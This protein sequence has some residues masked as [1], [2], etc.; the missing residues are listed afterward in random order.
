MELLQSYHVIFNFY[1]AKKVTINQ[2]AVR[3]SVLAPYAAIH[4]ATGVIWGS[5]YAKSMSGPIQLNWVP[6]PCEMEDGVVKYQITCDARDVPFIKEY[7][8]QHG[9]TAGPG[10]ITVA[11]NAEVNVQTA[12]AGTYSV[13]FGVCLGV[14]MVSLLSLMDE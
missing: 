12:G 5:V 10:F 13:L 8:A 9:L 14:L 2:V 11:P 4:D 6:F 7:N 3:G 1:Q